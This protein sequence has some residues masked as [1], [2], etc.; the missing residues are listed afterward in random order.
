MNEKNLFKKAKKLKRYANKIKVKLLEYHY[1]F[2][3][4]KRSTRTEKNIKKVSVFLFH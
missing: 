1:N 3:P 4:H 2:T